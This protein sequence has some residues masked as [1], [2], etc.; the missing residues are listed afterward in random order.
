MIEPAL[1]NRGEVGT[2]RFVPQR[3]Q[4]KYP[5]DL[6]SEGALKR[7]LENVQKDVIVR[8]NREQLKLA[9]GATTFNVA[10]SYMVMTAAGASTIATI[11]GGREGMILTLEFGDANITITDNATATA[12]TINLSAAF[13]SA[14]NDVLQLLYDGTSWR[15]VSRV[16]QAQEVRRF[17]VRLI[18]A[19]TD[20]ATDTTVGGD[21]RISDQAITVVDVGA[22]VD[23]A[24][25]TG[26]NLLTVDIHEAGTT[27]MTTNKITIDVGEKTSETAATPPA[28]TDTAIA[29]DAIVTFDI[30]QVNETTPA[31]GLVVWI[32]YIFT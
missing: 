12:D 18:A 30:D 20:L 5:L 23:T 26:S 21:Y 13:T 25:A 2:E 10:S 8:R 14:A 4:L 15:E 19:G 7:A 22:W 28:V 11:G 16:S 3:A 32:D 29:A 27:I 17:A 24:A 1:H 9:S 31:K 6:E